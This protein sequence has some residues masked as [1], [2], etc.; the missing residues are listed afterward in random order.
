MVSPHDDL[1]AVRTLVDTLSPFEME[2]QQRIIR[3]ACEKLG[4]T[5]VMPIGVG[6]GLQPST[7]Q[8]ETPP[9]S[10]HSPGHTV[11]PL[12]IKSF[13]NSK[14]PSNDMQFAT[15]VAYYFA[16]EASE[17]QRKESISSEDLQEACRKVGRERLQ[18]PGQTL[19]NAHHNGLL[20]KAGDRGVYKIN[21]VGENLVAVTLPGDVSTKLKKTIL[22]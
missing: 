10:I 20:D 18:N 7:I 9:K 11:T 19:R 2:E 13:V 6:S 4:I 14:K 15:T 16:F 5:N 3:W 21:T 17:A 8:P 22:Y 1:D 12:D